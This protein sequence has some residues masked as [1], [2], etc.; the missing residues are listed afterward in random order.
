[1]TSTTNAPKNMEKLSNDKSLIRNNHKQ[2]TFI[3]K[4]YD[5]V[6]CISPGGVWTSEIVDNKHIIFRRAQDAVDI[7]PGK[8]LNVLMCSLLFM[9]IFYDEL[10]SYI[11]MLAIWC[12]MV[13]I[14]A[15]D[16]YNANNGTY[17]WNSLG[18]QLLSMA[19]YGKTSCVEF[20]DTFINYLLLWVEY[21]D[22]YHVAQYMK[23]YD[24][25]ESSIEDDDESSIEDDDESSIE[26]DDSD[27]ISIVSECSR[28]THA[29][30]PELMTEEEH[31]QAKKNMDD[32]ISFY[33]D[34]Y[35]IHYT[36]AHFI[37]WVKNEVNNLLTEDY[38]YH[39]EQ[40]LFA[41]AERCVARRLTLYDVMCDYTS[42]NNNLYD[43]DDD[44]VSD[45]VAVEDDSEGDTDINS[46]EFI[47]PRRDGMWLRSMR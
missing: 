34:L 13:C 7:R 19:S 10:L 39:D 43:N 8:K 26:D 17:S 6:N 20:T 23:R 16:P 9:N 38:F 29:S 27:N 15:H 21:C 5:M 18:P 37:N 25:D 45:D 35:N 14:C 2:D 40:W 42:Y 31:E 28:K 11:L 30:M 32:C 36:N 47:R 41:L 1:M 22:D 24:D 3:Y 46:R 12:S 33:D 44:V 4:S